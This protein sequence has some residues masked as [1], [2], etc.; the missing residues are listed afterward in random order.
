MDWSI[1]V[2]VSQALL[3]SSL[4]VRHW[5]A[6]VIFFGLLCIVRWHK[7]SRTYVAEL[8]FLLFS[9]LGL[10]VF[11][12]WVA[13]SQG[14]AFWFSA[15]FMRYFM[16]LVPMMLIVLLKEADDLFHPPRCEGPTH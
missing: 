5:G 16:P 2:S 10:S 12:F 13:P 4:S 6:I 9:F 3:A 1:F 14:I 7:V 11:A 8:L 15:G